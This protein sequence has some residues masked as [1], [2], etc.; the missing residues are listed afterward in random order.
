MLED[1]N[2]EGKRNRMKLNNKKNKIMCN[3]VTRR[4]LENRRDDR[5]RKLK[6]G[7]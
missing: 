2:N 6:G 5:R 7:D 4:R 1:L 3:E